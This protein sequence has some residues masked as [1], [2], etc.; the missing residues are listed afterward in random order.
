MEG[1]MRGTDIVIIGLLLYLFAKASG[2]QGLL[3]AVN[4]TNPFS[5]CILPDVSAVPQ[6]TNIPA[7]LW[8][9]MQTFQS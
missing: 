4:G 1:D 7:P 3:N 5:T 8:T 6:S 9:T 2:G